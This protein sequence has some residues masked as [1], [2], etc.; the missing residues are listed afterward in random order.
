LN[1]NYYVDTNDKLNKFISKA[2]KQKVIA[3]DT[4]FLWRETYFPILGLIQVAFS[5]DECYLIDTIT[6]KDISAF[7]GILTNS[8]IVKILHDA[9][10]DLQILSRACNYII[11]VNIFDTRCAAGFAGLDH[12]ISLAK[13]IEELF[14]VTLPKSE[15]TT[16]WTK[17]P[18]TENQIQYAID[19]VIY[20][21][22][23]HD[24]LIR[25][26]KQNGFEPWLNDEMKMYE[27]SDIYRK[28]TPDKRYLKLK[29]IK[30]LTLDQ[31]KLVK[32]LAAWR[33]IEAE[34]K[35]IPKTF[36][37]KD[38]VLLKIV[39]TSPQNIQELQKSQHVLPGIIRKF[40][41]E[42]IEIIKKAE[43]SDEDLTQIQNNQKSIINGNELT[44]LKQFVIDKSKEYHIPI[45]LIATRA[46][47]IKLLEDKKTSNLGNNTLLK[48]WRKDIFCS[49]FM[50]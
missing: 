6:I 38:N 23:M 35:N 1:N 50:C 14:G 17:R 25:K 4:E 48:T 49:L 12:T 16:D 30:R 34:R 22:D 45:D 2:K 3:I 18:L 46:D 21:C 28:I 27:N 26:C 19:D 29:G 20:M 47:L 24:I 41:A 9:K 37:I 8:N 32:H 36:I 40:G 39:H 11:P 13:L 7:R 31:L 44:K 33:E 5:R 10:Q 15:T 42:I 43:S